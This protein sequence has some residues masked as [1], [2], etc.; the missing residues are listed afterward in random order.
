MT[1]L[2]SPPIL[3]KERISPK[4][5]LNMAIAGF[6]GFFLALTLAL[7]LEHTRFRKET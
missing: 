3:P 2:I 5:E 1:K 7:F 6:L 4:I